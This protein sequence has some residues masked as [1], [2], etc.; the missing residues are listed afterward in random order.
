MTKANNNG[1]KG[2]G[3]DGQLLGELGKT[4]DRD[5]V[6][7]TSG[8][9]QTNTLAIAHNRVSQTTP[10]VYLTRACIG[11]NLDRE[12]SRASSSSAFEWAASSAAG[13]QNSPWSTSEEVED[14]I[15]VSAK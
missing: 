3:I 11:E 10:V 9:K 12:N 15:R 14:M 6:K 7:Y 13:A 4:N 8:Q 2:P 5:V 1:D